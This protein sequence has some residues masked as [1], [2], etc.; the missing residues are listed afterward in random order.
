MLVGAAD[1][2]PQYKASEH[3][4]PGTA[5]FAAPAATSRY[6]K[7]GR[8]AATFAAQRL[9]QIFGQGNVLLLLDPP[10]NGQMISA[11]DRSTA[12]FAS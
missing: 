4:L 6:R 10:P 9:G 8:E 7:I 12:C 11:C 1:A 2:E 3:R 5:D